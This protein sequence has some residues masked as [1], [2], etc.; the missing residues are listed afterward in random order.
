MGKLCKIIY[1][2][3]DEK[4]KPYLYQLLEWLQD[5]NWPGA[6]IIAE[7]LKNYDNKNEIEKNVDIIINKHSNDKIWIKNIKKYLF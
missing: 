3:T 4:I 7:R 5:L 6:L 1:N 2:F